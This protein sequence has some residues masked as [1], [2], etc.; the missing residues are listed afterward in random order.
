MIELIKS[1][2]IGICCCSVI[3]AIADSLMPK[4]TV[5]KVSKLICGIILLIA[6][7]KPLLNIDLSVLSV[8]IVEYKNA[9]GEYSADISSVN[10]RLAK[11]IIEEQSAA[12]ILDKAINLGAEVTVQVTARMGDGELYYPDSVTVRGALS[13]EQR[14]RLEEIIA[15]ELAIPSERQ[16]WI[17]EN[18]E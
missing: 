18:Q 3:V 10:E 4:G 11:V 6:T 14:G 15:G 17:Q 7:V 5:K 16:S 1:W 2:L 8:N 13:E 12:Y 9:A